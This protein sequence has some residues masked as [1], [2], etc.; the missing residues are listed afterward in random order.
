LFIKVSDTSIW[1]FFVVYYLLISKKMSDRV[2]I[3]DTTLRDGEQVPGAKLNTVEK[4]EIAKQLD[5]L[6]V[7]I[8]EAGFPISSPEDFSAVEQV[9]R[10]ASNATI[11]ALARGLDKDIE[12]AARSI[13]KAKQPR[14]HTFISASDIHI[15]NQMKKSREEV[16]VMVEKAVKKAKS[17]V[18]DVEFS[19]MD[20]SRAD[21]D[22][23]VEFIKVAL[24]AG[25]TTINIPDTVG[26]AI[27]EEWGSMI[28]KL[29]EAIPA[30]KSDII[31]SVH[32]HND[33]GLATAN[34]LAGIENG[35][36]QVEGTINGIGERAGNCANEEIAMILQTRFKNRFTTGVN[37]KELF[38]TSRMVSQIM[39]LAVQP[40]KAI[41][42]ANA[43]AH[44]SGIHQDGIIKHRENFEI[45]NP[46]DVGVEESGI[47]LTARSGRSALIHRLEKI[48]YTVSD[49][50]RDALYEKFLEIADQK[51]EVYDEDLRL[52]MNGGVQDEG[53]EQFTLDLIQVLC[54]NKNIPTATVRIKNKNSETIHESVATGTGP[55]DAAF[56]AV[57]QITE[58]DIELK[59]YLV[60]AVTKGIDA[61]GKVSVQIEFDGSRYFGA[62]ADGDIIVASTQAY[63]RA[64]N[65]IKAND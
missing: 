49:N 21:F 54:G 17:Y 30:F 29:V 63:I 7:D 13:E 5:A 45:M 41:V 43:F 62:G 22:Y 6:G 12:V 56:K 11:C 19:P 44:S 52:I 57:D 18:D 8:I 15:E 2:F 51:K 40:N 61:H 50:E 28:A 64:I 24:A 14:L 65:Q 59:E 55:V 36:R 20:A 16:L 31:L 32:T 9:S 1:R 42:G 37:S 27:P 47:I 48:G 35:A 34:A 60:Q 26:Y 46:Q 38:R 23:L 39:G 4:I 58:F 33:L 3:F 25:A 10:I 53:K